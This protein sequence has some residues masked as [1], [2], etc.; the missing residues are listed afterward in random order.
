[1]SISYTINHIWEKYLFEAFKK[2]NYALFYKQIFFLSIE[3]FVQKDLDLLKE[4]DIG[5]KKCIYLS[6]SEPHWYETKTSLSQQFAQFRNILIKNNIFNADFYIPCFGNM[7]SSDFDILNYNHYGWNFLRYN[8]DLPWIN[9][10]II[11][12]KEYMS[13][14]DLNVKEIQYNFLHMNFTHRMHRQLFSKFLIKEKL[15]S[16]NCVAIN[17]SRN[18]SS[19]NIKFIKNDKCIALGMND[20]WVLSK[21]L[22]DL[23]KNYQLIDHVNP[24][25]DQE[26]DRATYNFVKLGAVY[27]ISETVFNHPYPRFTE[28]TISALLSHRPFIIIGAPN[29]LNALKEKGFATFDNFID[30]SYDKITDPTQRLEQIFDLV[31]SIN[32]KTLDQLKQNVLQSKDKLIHNKNLMKN[33]IHRYT[34]DNNQTLG[35][36]L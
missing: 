12:I 23:W 27:I 22:L 25:I 16:K 5:Q 28:K 36:T 24:E 35:A 14:D 10:D 6:V 18:E 34:E 4:N 19:N 15:M 20:S 29:S 17:T 3:E 26:F 31:K 2:S 7:Y 21:G 32:E 1:M 11:D 33:I 9:K 8:V 30:E 13:D